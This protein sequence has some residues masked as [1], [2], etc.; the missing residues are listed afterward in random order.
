MGPWQHCSA[1]CGNKGLH[2]RTVICVRPLSDDEQMALHDA[3]CP[4]HERPTEEEIC[5]GMPPCPG[6]ITWQTGPWS[7]VGVRLG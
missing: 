6:E 2:R 5:T 1:T 7:K 3:D 4:F